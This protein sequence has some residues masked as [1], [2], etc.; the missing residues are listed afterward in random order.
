MRAGL[1]AAKTSRPRMAAPHDLPAPYP[2][3]ITCI[4]AGD[5][6]D[7]RQALARFLAGQGVE[8]VQQA[9]DGAEALS[10]IELCR[11]TVAILDL[12]MPHL[13]GIEVTRRTAGV[14]PKTATIIYTSVTEHDALVEALRAGARG[15]VL[16]EA[17]LDVLL[18]AVLTVARGDVYV[19]PALGG[20]LSGSGGSGGNPVGRECP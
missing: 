5:H 15:L 2:T 14:A 6:P 11:P 19:D 17:P 4:V 10:A 1:A 7:S 3:G 12:V 18:R 9:A 13:G 16:K 20:A 8:V